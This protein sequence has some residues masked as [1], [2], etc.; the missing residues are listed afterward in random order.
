MV[1]VSC[2]GDAEHGV[3]IIRCCLADIRG[4]RWLREFGRAPGCDGSVPSEAQVRPRVIDGGNAG[5]NVGG[6]VEDAVAQI[7]L[8]QAP[9]ERV[10][11]R[12][13]LH[14]GSDRVAVREHHRPAFRGEPRR[15]GSG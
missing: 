1:G 8:G 15:T 7:S 4:N 10:V 14:T 6:V 12:I 2:G 13:R 3:E 11:N 5:G 9:E